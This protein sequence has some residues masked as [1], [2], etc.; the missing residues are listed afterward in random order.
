MWGHS[1][2]PR[3]VRRDTT[4][5]RSPRTSPAS[6]ARCRTCRWPGRPTGGPRW[7]PKSGRFRQD[8]RRSRSRRP[9]V[10]PRELLRQGHGP[11]HTRRSRTCSAE[12]PRAAG[13][14]CE[15]CGPPSARAPRPDTGRRDQ[16]DLVR[17]GPG[18]QQIVRLGPVGPRH[19]VRAGGRRRRR[20]QHP[21]VP[22]CDIRAVP[23]C[24]SRRS[25]ARNR[26]PRVLRPR[27]VRPGRTRRIAAAQSL[28]AKPA[29][30][31]TRNIRDPAPRRHDPGRR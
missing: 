11:E 9:P 1:G 25:M 31:A 8:H 30:T 29:R 4:S 18:R 19:P 7:F 24:P 21:H 5:Q 20:R 15:P 2:K 6:P 17:L 23:V 12:A 28:P 13:H 22:G 10:P 14:E 27:H 3:A 26:H 16:H